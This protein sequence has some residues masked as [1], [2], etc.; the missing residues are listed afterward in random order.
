M[1][2]RPAENGTCFAAGHNGALLNRSH[3]NHTI[4]AVVQHSCGHSSSAASSLKD[5][6]QPT[7][8]PQDAIRWHP[9]AQPHQMARSRHGLHTSWHPQKWL[10]PGLAL[11]AQGGHRSASSETAVRRAAAQEGGLSL[12]FLEPHLLLH[13]STSGKR[14]IWLQTS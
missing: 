14:L 2:S 5:H 9:M 3:N 6:Q 11:S 12:S 10:T 1:P 7:N 8:Q 4:I 13:A